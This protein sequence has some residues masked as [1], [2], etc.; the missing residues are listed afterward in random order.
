MDITTIIF[1]SET[2][3]LIILFFVILYGYAFHSVRGNA[4]RNSAEIS[5]DAVR[6]KHGLK[7]NLLFILATLLGEVIDIIISFFG[8]CI[9]LVFLLFAFYIIGN[10]IILVTSLL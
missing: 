2:R 9:S 6:G 3:E 1:N 8:A 5:E 4:L 7:R 10:V